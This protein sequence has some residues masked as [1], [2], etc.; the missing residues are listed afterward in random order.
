SLNPLVRCI[1]SH[2][3]HAM[4]C[5]YTEENR[6]T[7]QK[8]PLRRCFLSPT[9]S[10][11]CGLLEYIALDKHHDSSHRPD[12][13]AFPSDVSLPRSREARCATSHSPPFANVRCAR[14]E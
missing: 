11:G 9:V 1:A 14:L 4:E 8:G 2:T 3:P 12:H 13:R 6:Q 5:E 10:H 7:K